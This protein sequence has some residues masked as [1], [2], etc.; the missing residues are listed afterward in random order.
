MA[1]NITVLQQSYIV[2]RGNNIINNDKFL[3]K[4]VYKMFF[5]FLIL[6]IIIIFVGIVNMSMLNILKSKKD[7]FCYTICG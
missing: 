1:N 7:I 5:P 4:R 3:A 6:F 2:E